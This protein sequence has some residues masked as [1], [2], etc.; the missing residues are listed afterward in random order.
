MGRRHRSKIMQFCATMASDGRAGRVAFEKSLAMA[1]ITGTNAT[2]TL[3][4][5]GVL[6]T[7]QG[8]G[9]SD[10]IN[11]LGGA[12]TISGGDGRDTLLGGDGNDI[13]YGHSVAD[14]NPNSGNITATLLANVGSG[15]VFVTGAPGDDGFVYALRKDVG[16]IVRINTATGAQS[17]FLDI[18]STQFS[19]GGERG[20][21]G[22]AFHPDYADNG[23]F[24]VF[25]TNPA[26]NI[27]VREYARS[28]AN[29]AVADPAVVQTI[30][31]IP[32]P[33]F[34]NHNGGS[35][36]FGPDGYLYI[37]TGDGGG[38][39]DPNNNAQ[40][41][42][43]LLGKILRID[44]NGD[45][46]P[47]DS[48]RNYAIPDDNP[49]AG[50]TP[51]AAE[52][53]A[54]G[55][56]NPWRIS[57]DS[58][59]GDLYI[60]DVG[61]SAREEVNFEAAGG[62]GG[63]NY[64]W[65]YRE[66]KLQGPSAPPNPPIAFTEPVFD[67]PREIGHSITG[68][69]VYRGPAPGL[70]GAYFFAD[71]VTG[72][73]MTL[74]MV[75]GVAEDAIERTAQVVGADLQQISSFGT[76][77]AGNLY[78]VSLTGAI[79]RLDPG[80]AAGDGADTI[81]GGAGN[82]NLFGGA[83]NDRLIGGVGA[84]NMRGG[85][86]NDVYVVDN[87]GDIV[88]ESLAGS[89]GTDTVWSTRSFSLANTARV[90]GA[91]E[92]L[93]LLGS[94]GLSGTG[95]ALNNVI[96]GN[97]GANLLTGGAGND[98]LIGGAGADNMR[99]GAGNDVY[100]VDNAGDIVSENLAGSN[101]TDTVWSTRSF[102]LANTARAVG[103]VENLTLQG[104]A[105]VS[106]TGNALNNVITG[107]SG[108]NLL[109]GG[110]GNDR[111]I[112][113]A[114]ADNMRGGAGNDIYVVDNAGDIVSENL[115]GSN[116]TDT[117]WSTRSFS[118]A[119]TAHAVGAVE[120]LTLQGSAGISGTGNALNN[121]ITGNSGANLL[122]G[123][124]GN[125][126]LIGGA[127]ADN[128]RGGAGNDRLTGGAGPDTFFFNTALSAT[129]NIDQLTDFLAPAD[130]IWLENAVFTALTTGTLSAA[131]F[132]AGSAAHD[133]NDRVIYNPATGAVTYDLNGNAAGGVSHFATLAAGLTLTNADFVV[134]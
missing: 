40:N 123:G 5:T 128:M 111:L 96:T 29:P 44:V 20:V 21:L 11:G 64:G 91:V 61:Q 130:T 88:N 37:A 48:S 115:A 19:G 108:A 18:P 131:A 26:G 47:A 43:V 92:N 51:G 85:A 90:M 33:N 39:N 99:G 6:D 25:L 23:R 56:R 105:G 14:L 133:A 97:S 17:T 84:D 113:G 106:G 41:I 4:G 10:Q 134:V 109:T 68:G 98:R 129:T 50:A 27:E 126:R 78:V 89:N 42:N 58:L 55:L 35:L 118:L 125:D 8:L 74:R 70:Q 3:N 122:T 110:A 120:N 79:Y 75:N 38:A 87:A 86:G 83:G 13:I 104:S 103:A 16:D 100:V 28:D 24:F 116:G 1:N 127:G 81:D 95:N 107:N 54:Y 132:H 31:T 46:F 121:V 62:P 7:I 30:I 45:D 117:V 73:L 9:G 52:I 94:A 66:G 32:H 71:F 119:N 72:R 63:L 124:V 2:E 12:D 114:G 101:G 65:D 82:D 34:G 49:F 59:T 76:D 22:L 57:F 80:I 112:G 53:W 69:Y 36:A 77:N 102:S 67:Y 15:A 93:T 60:G